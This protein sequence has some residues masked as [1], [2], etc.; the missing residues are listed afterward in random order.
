MRLRPPSTPLIT[1]DPYF[2][3]WSPADRLTDAVICHWTGKP[4]TMVG[5]AC[6]DGETYRFMGKLHQNDDSP[7]LTQTAFD[8]DALSTRYTF[9]GAGV[10]LKLTF[11]TP[12]L[13]D[14]L[15]VMTRPVS[16]LEMETASADGA[17]HDVTVKIAVSE[18]ICLNLRSQSPVVT[19]VLDVNGRPTVKMGNS[20]QN[21]LHCSGD[22][23]RIDWGYFYL[24]PSLGTAAAETINI[25]YCPHKINRTEWST[26]PEDYK[27]ETTFVTVTL[28]MHTCHDNCALVT[29][30]YDDIKSIE[31]FGDH[32]TSVWNK[33]GM[34]IT[35]AIDAA[36][37]EYVP[38]MERCT[39]FAEKMFHDAVRAGGEK[40]AEIC[41]L[42]YRQAIA[43]HKVA[44]DTE[45]QIL[46]ISKE[47][48]S[49]GC[50]ATV[51]VSYPSIP[52]FLLYNPEL[53]RGMMR[54]IYRFARSDM[55]AFDFAPH[56]A[57]QYPLVNCQRY[58]LREGELKLEF[59]MPVEECGNMLVMAAAVAL[60]DKET[61]FAEENM[62]LLEA[63]VKYL[64]A[65]GYD[66]ENQ[67][68]T[69]DFAGH[70]AHNCNLSLKA[71]MGIAGLALIYRML[72]RD[73]DADELMAEAKKMADSFIA[74]ASNGDG[75]FRLAYDRP[76]TW[77]MKYNAIWDKLWG[78]GIFD[79]MVMQSEFASYRKH[80]NP[81]GMPLDNRSDYTK[82]DWLIWT[83]TLAR[84]KDDFIDY[85]TPL[86]KNYHHTA[87]RVPATDWYFTT[88]SVQR[89]FQHRTVVGGHFMKLLEYT[90]KMAAK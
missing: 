19:E 47:C 77:S 1:V 41:E 88:T 7:V 89:G 30:A 68:C 84:E 3:V 78:T 52:L 16:Y 12:L 72:G 37:N 11:T 21:V 23:I 67:L 33:D 49:N 62:D 44:V 13:M 46:F 14:D 61:K 83:G 58:G 20:E 34:T 38:L 43:A 73:A 9:A 75:S 6:I 80:I 53:V 17:C 50:A 82:S 45:G 64:I 66:P 36:Y 70:L 29:F 59:Q 71:I 60:A 15:A 81:Y 51:D 69:D 25:P 8:F 63:W 28:P 35:E 26:A 4:N 76:G 56:D 5:T 24:T 57:G 2:T 10:V 85:V 65:N 74:R 55:W 42:S 31:Y 39:A 18:E 79:P 27:E 87:S 22:D 86:W 90:G 40:Y 48:F 32:L 54:P